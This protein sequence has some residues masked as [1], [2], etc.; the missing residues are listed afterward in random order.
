MGRCETE[1]HRNYLLCTTTFAD[2]V[3]GC[4]STANRSERG[5]QSDDEGKLVQFQKSRNFFSAVLWLWADQHHPP[6]P[7]ARAH[8]P[9][10]PLTF[11]WLKRFLLLEDGRK[12]LPLPSSGRFPVKETLHTRCSAATVE[13]IPPVFGK[14]L[15][16][17]SF[18][19]APMEK[20]RAE[21]TRFVTQSFQKH[22][23]TRDIP[24]CKGAFFSVCPVETPL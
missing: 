7:K 11:S 18:L 16:A 23:R 13:K 20:I 8:H 5:K 6:C 14:E 19:P 2:T 9:A 4:L 12:S 10:M 15:N 22:L 3:S 17:P 21:A 24:P 1:G